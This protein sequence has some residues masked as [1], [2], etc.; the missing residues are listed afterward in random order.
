MVQKDYRKALK[1]KGWSETEV[2][3]ALRELDRV[4]Q[5]DVFFA[6][7]GFY[8]ALL[9]VVLA[10]I[11]ISFTLLFLSLVLAPVFLY[12]VVLLL[13][14]VIGFL[15]HFLISDIGHIGKEHHLLA[16]FIIP[17]IALVNLVVIVLVANTII[18]DLALT[19]GVHNAW[20]TAVV[21]AI[22]LLLPTLLARVLRK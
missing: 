12:V 21:F 5:Q 2:Q 20:L 18:A 6:K 3:H 13:G 1:S 9:V 15:Y 4:T 19:T 16:L 14:L 10:N 22:S 8:S 11:L 17:A 7:V